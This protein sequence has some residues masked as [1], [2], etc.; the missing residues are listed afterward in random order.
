MLPDIHMATVPNN[1]DD[2][3]P[4]STQ[5]IAQVRPLMGFM[6]YKLRFRV[7]HSTSEL[8]SDIYSIL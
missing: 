6:N 1:F 3:V 5:K 2:T 7:S 8:L 4:H